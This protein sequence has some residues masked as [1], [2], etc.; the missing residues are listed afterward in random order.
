MKLPSI[1]PA[2][3]T[4]SGHIPDWPRPPPRPPLRPPPAGARPPPAQAPAPPPGPYGT[5]TTVLAASPP[6]TP[7]SSGM[8]PRRSPRPALG[9]ASVSHSETG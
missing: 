3:G 2:G 6:T 1:P 7:S 4:G 9:T 8:E 5:S